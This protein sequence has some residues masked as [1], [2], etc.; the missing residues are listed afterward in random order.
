MET[1]KT[2]GGALADVEVH[3][4]TKLSALWT[5][6]MLCYLY[7]DYLTLFVPGMLEGVAAGRMPLGSTSQLNLLAIAIFVSIPAVMIFL[8][9]T[10]KPAVNR[11]ANIVLGA[12]YAGAVLATLFMDPWAYYVFLGIVEVVL[13]ALIVRYAWTWPGEESGLG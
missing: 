11:W 7:G 5:S 8:S 9:L 3:V 12:V 6:V 10:L 2:T 13:S 4:R 1:T